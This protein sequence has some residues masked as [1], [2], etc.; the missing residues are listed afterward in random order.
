MERSEPDVTR[1]SF[2][3]LMVNMDQE[4]SLS[5]LNVIFGCT[6]QLV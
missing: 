1:L 2:Q 6:S 3:I 4:I 5:R